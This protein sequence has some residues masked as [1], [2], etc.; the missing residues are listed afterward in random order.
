MYQDQDF[1]HQWANHLWARERALR[2]RE[3]EG[4]RDPATHAKQAARSGDGFARGGRVARGA[5]LHG[6]FFR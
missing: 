5:A 4:E 3:E 1:D 2:G 6:A